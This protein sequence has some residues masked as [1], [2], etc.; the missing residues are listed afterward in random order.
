MHATDRLRPSS[1]ADP[2]F[3]RVTTANSEPILPGSWERRPSAGRTPVPDVIRARPCLR[4]NGSIVGPT[5]VLIAITSGTCS[6]LT[7][8]RA[9]MHALLVHR[10]RRHPKSPTE[11]P[12]FR[13]IE[14]RPACHPSN[15][16]APRTTSS[17]ACGD[18]PRCAAM[19]WRSEAANS[20]R[21]RTPRPPQCVAPSTVTTCSAAM[22]L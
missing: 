6:P 16:S 21:M 11:P 2:T 17:R 7:R 19:N 4:R 22:P 20:G 13:P 9:R 5:F 10:S 1:E 15:K 12:I 18:T 14:A 8:A 3:G